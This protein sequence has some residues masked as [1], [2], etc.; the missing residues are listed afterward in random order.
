MIRLTLDDQFERMPWERIDAVVFDVGNVLLTFNPQQI[1]ERYLPARPELHQKLLLRMFR[2]PYWPMLDHGIATPAELVDA[3]T[4]RDETLRP[5]VQLLM[6]SWVEMKD[7]I[8]EGVAVLRRCKEMGKRLFVLSNYGDEAFSVVD[9]K[10][11]FFRLFDGKLVS[12]RE[13]LMKPNPAIYHLL[14]ERYGL[15]AERTL[16]IDDAPQ[17]IE[18]ALY[19]GWQGLCYDQPGKLSTFFGLD[20]VPG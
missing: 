1:L 11:D 3:M 6:N 19:C 7:V 20:S 15:K 10:Y 9:G 13:E 5:A 17:N 2:S 18:A 4:G 8:G 14:T 16:F 12:S